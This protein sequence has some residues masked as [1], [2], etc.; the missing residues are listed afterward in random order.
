MTRPVGRPVTKECGTWQAYKRHKRHK[1][2]ACQPCKDAYAEWMRDYYA[3]T[4]GIA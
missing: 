1:E 4:H 3:R 2:D